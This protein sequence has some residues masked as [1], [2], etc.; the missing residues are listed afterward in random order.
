MFSEEEKSSVI[1]MA[2][3]AILG[4]LFV[5]S[6]LIARASSDIRSN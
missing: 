4:C 5:Q 2:I 1:T 6:L 3:P